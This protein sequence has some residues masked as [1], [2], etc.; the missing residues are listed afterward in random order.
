[1]S[2]FQLV[3][4]IAQELVEELENNGILTVKNIRYSVDIIKKYMLCESEHNNL[5]I[6]C[7]IFNKEYDNYNFTGMMHD[8][9]ND[10]IH[11]INKDKTIQVLSQELEEICNVM[12]KELIN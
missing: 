4:S 9:A 11:L 1:M 7:H 3:Q 2:K 10:L 6:N 5:L 12:L 8:Y